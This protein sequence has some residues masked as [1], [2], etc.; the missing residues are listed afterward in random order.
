VG[1]GEE[2]RRAMKNETPL[3]KVRRLLQRIGRTA[4]D[5]PLDLDAMDSI[6]TD[7]LA[8]LRAL[9]EAEGNELTE[10]LAPKAA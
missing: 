4:Q 6:C 7:S 8:A 3:E 1:D 5:G 9:D 10:E 2:G